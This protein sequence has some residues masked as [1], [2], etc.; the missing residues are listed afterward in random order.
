MHNLFLVS[1]SLSCFGLFLGTLYGTVLKRHRITDLRTIRRARHARTELRNSPT[2]K[3]CNIYR[4]KQFRR[5]LMNEV[6]QINT[7]LR[8]R[9]P[10]E[11]YQL[12]HDAQGEIRV[13]S[14]TSQC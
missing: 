3:F 8:I 14:K 13:R 11:R 7:K 4:A 1:Y 2:R 10:R 5:R 12:Y 9:T 6:N